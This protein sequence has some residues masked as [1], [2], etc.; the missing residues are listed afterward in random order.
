M[1]ATSDEDSERFATQSRKAA[2]QVDRLRVELRGLLT[3]DEKGALDA[4]DAAWAKV[5]QVDARLLPL[6]TANTNLKA[7]KLSANE[8]ATAL[9]VVLGALDAAQA[10]SKDPA[11]LRELSAASVAALRVQAL[12][13]PHIDSPDDA[14]MTALEAKA[15]ALEQ[16]V[17]LVLAPGPAR[18]TPA[19]ETQALA[20][21]LQ[22]WADYQALTEKIFVLSRQNTNVLSFAISIHEKSEAT[23]AC[24]AALQAL[25]AQLHRGPTATR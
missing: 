23:V 21:A 20:P 13:S 7:A 15:H 24:Q 5:G 19:A 25:A 10:L 18:K 22:A 4:F 17:D 8:A 9:D 2:E 1:L 12:H 3:S 6:A 14:E 16:Q 11:R